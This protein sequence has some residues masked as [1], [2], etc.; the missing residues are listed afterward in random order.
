VHFQLVSSETRES[1]SQIAS[2]NHLFF[3]P[4]SSVMPVDLDFCFGKLGQGLTNHFHVH[5]IGI[6]H[7]S[8]VVVRMISGA[9]SRRAVVYPTGV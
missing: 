3:D 2:K 6:Q 7:I 5:A 4:R 9:N 1:D 8:G